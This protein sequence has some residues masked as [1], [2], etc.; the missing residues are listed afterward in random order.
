MRC[1]GP[2]T[3]NRITTSAVGTS[4]A[5]M[6]VRYDVFHYVIQTREMQRY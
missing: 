1:S 3:A 6:D 4:T 5:D 2:A